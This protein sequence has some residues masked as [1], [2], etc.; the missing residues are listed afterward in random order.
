VFGVAVSG[1]DVL[2]EL[3][4]MPVGK[5]GQLLFTITI[6]GCG[7]LNSGRD[8]IRLDEFNE[9]LQIYRKI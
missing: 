5:D 4:Q 2:D 3:R 8:H 7:E 9:H 1:F 6:F